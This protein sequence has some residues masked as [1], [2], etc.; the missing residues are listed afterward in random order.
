MEKTGFYQRMKKGAEVLA[1]AGLAGLAAAGCGR[2][3]RDDGSHNYSGRFR[4]NYVNVSIYP[5]GGRSVEI[6][7]GKDSVS[8]VDNSGDSVF[9]YVSFNGI[10]IRPGVISMF[11]SSPLAKY[12]NS[13]SLNVAAQEV[14]RQ[15]YQNAGR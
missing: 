1:V 2:A 3:F 11:G 8:G 7:D 4:G 14:V 9:D 15:T 12:A 5:E 10:D 6:T 13:D